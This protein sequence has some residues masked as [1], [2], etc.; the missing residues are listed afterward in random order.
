MSERTTYAELAQQIRELEKIESERKRAEEASKRN[1]QL[2]K[3][4]RGFTPAATA[5]CDLQMRYSAYRRR[6]I[7]DY[8][9]F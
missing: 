6:W 9:T 7:I 5:M 2:L 4:Y 1:A 8:K 3:L